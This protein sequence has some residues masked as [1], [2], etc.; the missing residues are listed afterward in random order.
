MSPWKVHN[1]LYAINGVKIAWREEG[2]FKVLAI[3]GA[4]ALLLSWWL[5]ISPSEWTIM[6]LL[7]G[8]VLAAEFVNTALEELCDMYKSDPDPHIGKIKDLAA[9]AVLMTSIAAFVIGLIIFI[10]RIALL[11]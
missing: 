4:L 11:V 9:A 1:F 3:A 7:I 10:P 2:S 5:G 6:V 8:L